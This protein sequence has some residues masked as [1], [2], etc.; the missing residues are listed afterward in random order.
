VPVIKSP[1]NQLVGTLILT[2]VPVRFQHTHPF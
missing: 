1:S 2:K